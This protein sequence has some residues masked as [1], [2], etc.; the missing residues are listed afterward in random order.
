MVYL[1]TDYWNIQSN[2]EMPN[3]NTDIMNG[4]IAIEAAAETKSLKHFIFGTLPH[5]STQLT[6]MM[7]KNIYHFRKLSGPNSAIGYHH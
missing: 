1:V 2:P 7:W 6:D 4:I 3:L 5:I